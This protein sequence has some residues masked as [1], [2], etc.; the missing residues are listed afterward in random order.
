VPGV[1][2][3]NP[4][5]NYILVRSPETETLFSG[6]VQNQEYHL[7][8]EIPGTPIV[9][10]KT[11]AFPSARLLLPR[12]SATINIFLN[13]LEFSWKT[14]APYCEMYF[15]LYYTDVYPDTTIARCISW[16]DYHS[17][18][19][20]IS[21]SNLV[22]GQDVMKRIGNLVKRDPLVNYR[23]VTGFRV[24]IVGIPADLYEYRLMSQIQPSDQ[25]GFPV[26]NIVNGIGLFTSQT[27]SDFDLELDPRGKDSI[28]NSQYTRHL[29]F[30]F[31]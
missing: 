29:N 8:V 23:P 24:F 14:Y 19:P 21:G 30:R 7:T 26:T 28:M 1:F 5:W 4:N 3:Q 2:T 12:I 17:V 15:K 6:T 10:A 9:F 20:G 31:Y 18:Q 16:R 27:I 13:P 22:Y 25:I 11:M